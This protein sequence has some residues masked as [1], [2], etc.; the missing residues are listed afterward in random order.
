M[1]CRKNNQKIAD[2]VASRGGIAPSANQFVDSLARGSLTRESTKTSPGTKKELPPQ[3]AEN[4][5]NIRL[6]RLVGEVWWRLPPYAREAIAFQNVIITDDDRKIPKGYSSRSKAYTFLYIPENI[7]PLATPVEQLYK[8]VQRFMVIKGLAKEKDDVV[9]RYILAHELAHLVLRHA[10]KGI[11]HLLIRRN[12]DT[13]VKNRKQKRWFKTDMAKEMGSVG[14]FHEDH[15]NL[16]A[17]LWGFNRNDSAFNKITIL[18]Q[19]RWHKNW[20]FQVG[21]N[22]YAPEIVDYDG[23]KNNPIE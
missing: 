19:P 22:S 6:K 7:D 11:I 17:S 1:S 5:K 18:E 9:A 23:F 4:I 10:D 21:E 2:L 12:V 8:K 14:M 20:P 16:L 13:R 15:A 3:M